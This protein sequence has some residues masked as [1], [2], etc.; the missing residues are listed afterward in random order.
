M[1]YYYF[2]TG[3]VTIPA[4]LIAGILWDVSPATM[5]AYTTGIAVMALA[6]LNFVK[7]R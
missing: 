6:L 4:G 5:F 3:I 7:S 2:I 1:G